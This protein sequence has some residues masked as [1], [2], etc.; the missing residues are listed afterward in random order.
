MR[1]LLSNDKV[2]HW[3]SSKIAVE[4]R[5][6]TDPYWGLGVYEVSELL[7][8]NFNRNSGILVEHRLK[9]D[10]GQEYPHYY[11]YWQLLIFNF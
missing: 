7:H 11:T 8:D 1:R 10:S 3:A 4:R 2:F 6:A 5:H 9:M